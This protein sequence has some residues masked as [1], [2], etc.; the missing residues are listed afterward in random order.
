MTVFYISPT[1]S[2]S[3]SGT[4]M[5][6]AATIYDLPRLVATAGAGDEV[7]LLADRGAY[8]V[9]KQ[10]TISDG[11]AAGAPGAIRGVDSSG[12]PMK[13]TIVGTRATDWKPGLEQG[14]ELFRLASGADHLS[15]SDLAVKNVGNG[16]FRIGADLTDLTIKH[17]AATNVARFLE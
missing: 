7:R 8:N 15:F 10:I 13:A 5:A 9:T 2:G 16:V 12:A 6:N 1:G 14:V 4:S 17:V 3:H 11:G